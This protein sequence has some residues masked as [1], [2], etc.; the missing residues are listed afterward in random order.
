MASSVDAKVASAETKYAEPQPPAYDARPSDE[1]SVNDKDILGRENTNPV[2]TAKMRLV[3]NAMDEIGLTPYHWKLFVLNGFGYAVDSLML[4]IQSV[5]AGAAANEFKPSFP[6]GLTIA[7]YIGMLVGA[8]FWGLS[9]DIIGRK[10]AFNISLL[11]S[12]IFCIIAGASPNWVGLGAFVALSAFG[13]GG[14][15]VLD[16]A[17]FL[18]YLPSSKQWL[19]TLMAS[20]WGIGQL[21][22]GLFAWA[23]LPKYSCSDA[24]AT[25][26]ECNWSNNAGW[27]YVWF[28]SGALVFVMSILRITVIR[29]NETPKFLVGEGKDEEVVKSLQYIAQKYNKPCSLTIEQLRACGVTET[30][31]RDAGFLAGFRSI[32]GHFS[33]LFATRKMGL[34]T[35]LIWF[36]WALIGLIYPLYYVFLPSYLNA[37]PGI[38][39]PSVDEGWR[40]YAIA[41]VASVPGPIVAAFMCNSKFFWGRR[42]TMIIGALL[43][44]AFFFAFTAVQTTP[45]NVAFSCVIGFCL[46]IYYGTLYAYTPEVLPSAHR[47]TGNG[48]A[49][50]CNRIMGIM[51]ALVGA[52]ANKAQSVPIFIC[53]AFFAVM[54]LVAAAFPYEPRGRRSS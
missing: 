2:L 50:A 49:I 3:N 12:A 24:Q 19:V 6:T 36:S 29:L 42:G 26:G 17:V 48:V 14:N 21:I 10:Y 44:M 51:S 22:T 46:N 20:W 28:A 33:G 34:S 43:T 8:L 1:Y 35:A 41:N 54:A 4:L 38:V 25:A 9:A 32:G 16:T 37:R 40:N 39:P 13:S 7:V 45:Q 52:Y 31:H 15:L 53:A 30:G 27:R 47:G 5:I 23:F 11:F 18:E